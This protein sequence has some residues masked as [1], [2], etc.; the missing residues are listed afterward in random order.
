MKQVLLC[1]ISLL[2]F[3]SC[4]DKREEVVYVEEYAKQLVL[5]YPNFK[6]NEIA[7][8]AVKDSIR[9]HVSLFIGGHPKDIDGVK[10]RFE[11]LIEGK[12]GYCA[13]FTASQYIDVESPS[14]GGSKYIGAT[15]Q[16]MAFGNVDDVVASSLDTQKYYK[17][18][19]VLH[20]WDEDNSIPVVRTTYPDRMD[21]GT[22]ILDD[23]T[24]EEVQNE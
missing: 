2:L 1:V 9:A 18:G 10:F 8:A 5:K 15:I 4:D 16:M 7:E 20:A 14:A 17:L 23:M 3:F 19:G 11:K 22:Y 6:A 12:N 13:L 21:F 24:V